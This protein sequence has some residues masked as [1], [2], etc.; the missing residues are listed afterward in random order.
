MIKLIIGILVV[1]ILAA[2]AGV[3][4]FTCGYGD[5]IRENLGLKKAPKTKQQKEAE[6]PIRKL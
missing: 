4:C 6:A 1:M 5:S 2:V 3:D